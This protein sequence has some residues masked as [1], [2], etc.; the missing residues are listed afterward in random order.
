M[1]EV[2]RWLKDNK[3]KIGTMESCTGGL[4]A[5]NIT[6]CEGASEVFS[7]GRVT[8]SNREKV[9]NGVSKE[10]IEEYGVYSGEIAILMAKAIASHD[11]NS[12]GVGITGTLGNVDKNNSDSKIGLVYFAIVYRNNE[13]CK[14]LVS[15]YLIVNTDRFKTRKEQKEFVVKAVID[16]L[17]LSLISFY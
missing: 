5:S 1:K 3:I 6:D 4:L 10:A 12:L 15:D 7:C 2:I 16:K 8:Y 13:N 11:E 14:V 17:K 9:I